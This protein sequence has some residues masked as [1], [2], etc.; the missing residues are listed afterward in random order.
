M[1]RSLEQL[2]KIIPLTE[3]EAQLYRD[4]HDCDCPMPWSKYFRSPFLGRLV[5]FRVCCLIKEVELLTGKQLSWVFDYSPTEVWDMKNKKERPSPQ[6]ERR[7]R[8]KGIEIRN[9]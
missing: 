7:M 3:G 8:E 5:E 6:I 9:L 2:E 4:T 1:S